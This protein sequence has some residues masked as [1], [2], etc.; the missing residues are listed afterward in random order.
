MVASCVSTSLGFL[1]VTTCFSLPE[2][3]WG[4]GCSQY[5]FFPLC[6]G[7]IHWRRSCLARMAL[8]HQRPGRRPGH[9]AILPGRLEVH[10]SIPD[11]RELATGG[12]TA[13][14]TINAAFSPALFGREETVDSGVFGRGALIW[15]CLKSVVCWTGF[16]K[17]LA[18]ASLQEQVA[19][20]SVLLFRALHRWVFGPGAQVRCEVGMPVSFDLDPWIRWQSQGDLWTHQFD[21]SSDTNPDKGH[22]RVEV[23]SQGCFFP[24]SS[25]EGD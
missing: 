2:Y 15:Q 8:P 9:W 7:S 10:Q 24:C 4:H 22:G 12:P 23:H 1:F 19:A 21:L 20:V 13:V 5:V 3:V 25:S 17:N 11:C 14:A 6:F 18:L 16:W